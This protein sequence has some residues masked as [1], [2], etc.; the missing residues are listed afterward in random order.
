[1]IAADIGSRSYSFEISDN[2]ISDLKS[3]LRMDTSGN[4]IC[5]LTISGDMK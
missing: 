3:Q 2:Y 5:R 4:S 1:M